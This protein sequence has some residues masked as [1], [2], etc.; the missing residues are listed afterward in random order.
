MTSG[1]NGGSLVTRCLATDFDI[2]FLRNILFQGYIDTLFTDKPLSLVHGIRAT[3]FQH[4]Q[5][6]F[7][8]T[9]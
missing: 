8:F 9:D 2:E 7:R 3:V 1:Y 6:I 5:L 4:F